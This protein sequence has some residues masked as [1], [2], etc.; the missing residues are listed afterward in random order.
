MKQD[1][2]AAL[3][4]LAR[5]KV[6]QARATHSRAQAAILHCGQAIQRLEAKITSE[7]AHGEAMSGA[8]MG[9]ADQGLIALNA[10]LKR[11]QAAKIQLEAL[12]TQTL[13]LLNQAI[14]AE[15]RYAIHQARLN[16]EKKRLQQVREIAAQDDLHLA[17]K[18]LNNHI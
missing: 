11:E 13:H 15:E 9:L 8:A 1:P 12:A 7:R 14:L 17:R 18:R 5:M 3:I 16:K 10:N 4:K 6:D 2:I